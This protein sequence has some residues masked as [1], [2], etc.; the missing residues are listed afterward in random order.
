MIYQLARTSPLLSGQVKMNMIMNGNK[1]TSIQYVPI[2]TNIPFNY[3]NPVDVLNYSHGENV[4]ML[5]NQIKSSFFSSVG[6]KDLSVNNLH[7]FEDTP[8]DTHD[9]T[10]EMGMKRMEYQRYKKQFEFFCPIWC[11]TKKEFDSMVFKLCLVNEKG[12]LLYSRVI[13]FEE[14]IKKYFSSVYESLAGSGSSENTDLLYIDFTGSTAYIKGLNVETGY[15]Q[16]VDVS[17]IIP[18]LTQIERTVIETDNILVKTFSDNKISATQLFN[19]NFVFNLEDMIPSAMIKDFRFEKINA[20]IDVYTK[21]DNGKEAFIKAETK[22]IYNN[23]D[24]IPKY[25][26]DKGSFFIDSS[27]Q[28]YNV[29]SYLSD[30]KNIDTITKNRLLGTTFHWALQENDKIIFNLYNGFSPMIN[31]KNAVSG[32]DFVFTDFRTDHF[33]INKNPFGIFKYTN[34]SSL[35]FYNGEQ[36]AQSVLDKSSFYRFEINEEKL[37]SEKFSNFGPYK[38]NNQK[39]LKNLKEYKKDISPEGSKGSYDKYYYIALDENENKDHVKYNDETGPIKIPT[40]TLFLPR[41][42]PAAVNL[43][44][45]LINTDIKYT[46][47]RTVLP[48]YVTISGMED[49][50]FTK[51]NVSISIIPRP[52]RPIDRSVNIISKNKK[53]SRPAWK[54]KCSSRNFIASWMFENELYVA[55]LISEFDD[56]VTNSMY[57]NKMIK[58]DYKEIRKKQESSK[59]DLINA[60][61]DTAPEYKYPVLYYENNYFPYAGNISPKWLVYNAFN[62]ALVLVK[63]I[64]LNSVINLNNS[65]DPYKS[66]SPDIKTDE[67]SYNQIQRYITLYRYDRNLYPAFIDINEKELK[68]K[69]YWC[70]QYENIIKDYAPD[71]TSEFLRLAS[72]K[73]GPLY[74]SI[75]YTVLKSMSIDYKDFYMNAYDSNSSYADKYGYSKEI[76]WYKNNKLYYFPSFIEAEKELENGEDITEEKINELFNDAIKNIG[77]SVDESQIKY[78]RSMYFYEY[79]CEYISLTDISKQKITIKFYL[80]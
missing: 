7:K 71:N 73:Y 1:V 41:K 61:A 4:K 29:L 24:Y 12:D 2:S 26:I 21:Q 64:A 54:G 13:E 11:D 15:V 10:Y 20:Y 17:Y 68:N 30:P 56:T 6:R 38:V 37:N 33:D 44:I 47:L 19:F 70:K 53:V 78:I 25:D 58:T 55:F 65:L 22:D 49:I 32:I 16:T 42:N 35:H 62:F 80:K 34:I 9:G 45:F 57:Y 18:N 31:S 8:D 59:M 40:D 50:E 48:Y 76:S 23:Y 27:E 67:I 63:S 72:S 66:N 79:S 36:I 77:I 74:P 3:K 69:V 39:F 5:Y 51:N 43:G 14:K 75:N 52:P 60:T 46:V 28:K